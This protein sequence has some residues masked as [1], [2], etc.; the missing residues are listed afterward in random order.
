MP[1]PE[2]SGGASPEGE[3][4]PYHHAA[5]YPGERPARQAYNKAQGTIYRYEPD[6]DLSA[7]RLQI[8]HAWHV[9]VVGSPPPA[10]LDERLR[11]ILATGEITTLPPEL[12]TMLQKR[13][14]EATQ[15]GPW[16]EGHYRPGKRLT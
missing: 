11:T 6:C 4:P 13:R 10:D 15:L 8:N 7:Y 5:R 3:Q 1:S 12:L 9:A 16:V 14:A 2:R